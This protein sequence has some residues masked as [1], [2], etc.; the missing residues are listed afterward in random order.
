MAKNK[1]AD[2]KMPDEVWIG[3]GIKKAKHKHLVFVV[4]EKTEDGR[5]RKLEVLYDD[6]TVTI[7]EGME[8]VTGYVP[9]HVVTKKVSDGKG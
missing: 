8:F 1:A 5:P 9:A 2:D 3:P 6:E 7:C 4:K